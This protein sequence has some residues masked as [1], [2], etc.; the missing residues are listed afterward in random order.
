MVRP[1]P[2]KQMIGVRF[3]LPAPTYLKGKKLGRVF[4]E[5]AMQRTGINRTN[6]VG[7]LAYLIRTKQATSQGDALKR[8]ESGEF[9]GVD[10]EDLIITSYQVNKPETV[11][12][13]DDE[14]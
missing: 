13:K 9:D 5:P 10:F 7:V 1:L 3:S 6:L 8:L 4:I 12:K 11:E 2:S 14:E